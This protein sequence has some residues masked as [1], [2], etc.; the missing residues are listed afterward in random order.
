MISDNSSE[1]PESESVSYVKMAR[2][3]KKRGAC[4][5]ASIATVTVAADATITLNFIVYFF[6]QWRSIMLAIIVS[7]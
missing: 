5:L 7:I 2:P 6:W 4:G 3:S 1:I